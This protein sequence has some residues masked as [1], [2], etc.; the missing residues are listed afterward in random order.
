MGQAPAEGKQWLLRI[1]IESILPDRIL[2]GLACQRVFQFCGE[3]WKAVQEQDEVKAL[4]VLLAVVELAN[5]R[6]EIG[7]V[8]FL[9]CFVQAACRPEVGEPERAAIRLDALS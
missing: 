7:L 4:L 2:H 5:D 8:K 3:D 1:A 6:E 9:Q